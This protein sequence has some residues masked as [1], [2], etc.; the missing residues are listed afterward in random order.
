MEISVYPQG[1]ANG[2]L[3]TGYCGLPKQMM[4][5]FPSVDMLLMQPSSKYNLFLWK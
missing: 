3:G 4:R 2:H 1:P 5:R